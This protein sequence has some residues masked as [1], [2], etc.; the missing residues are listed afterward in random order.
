MGR[1]C[2]KYPQKFDYKSAQIP[3]PL[4]PEQEAEK[5]AKVNEKKKAQR[6]AKREKVKSR[7]EEEETEKR[8]KEEKERFLNLSDREKRALAAERRIMANAKSGVETSV[9]Q[10]RCYTCAVDMTGKVPFEYSDYRFCTVGCL[11]K[12]RDNAREH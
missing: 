7:R 3:P 11:K 10:Q 12:H 1:S 4:S 6:L 9:V 2:G 8:E 5:A